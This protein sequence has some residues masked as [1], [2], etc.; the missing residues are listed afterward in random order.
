MI[1]HATF[2]IS[3][4]RN[5]VGE[6]VYEIEADTEEEANTKADEI[7]QLLNKAINIGNPN[8]AL[9]VDGYEIEPEEEDEE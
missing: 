2:T 1:Y 8:T 4:D 3:D 6:E 7:Q 5:P 9:W